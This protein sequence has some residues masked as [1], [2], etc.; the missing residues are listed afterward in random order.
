MVRERPP[1]D[2]AQ[3]PQEARGV[4]ATKGDWQ[5]VWSSFDQRRGAKGQAEAANEAGG[6]DEAGGEPDMF[7]GSAGAQAAE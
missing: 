1:G 4:I 3:G 6:K 5:S 2:P 7:G